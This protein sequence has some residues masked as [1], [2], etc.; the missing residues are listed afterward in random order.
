MCKR[1]AHQSLHPAFNRIVIPS[2]QQSE[3]SHSGVVGHNDSP[4]CNH[5]RGKTDPCA[6]RVAASIHIAVPKFLRYGIGV[7]GVQYALSRR[8]LLIRPQDSVLVALGRSD[9]VR[10]A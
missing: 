8:A 7:V 5:G 3:D 9:S 2:V 10:A 1:L 4:L 6:Q